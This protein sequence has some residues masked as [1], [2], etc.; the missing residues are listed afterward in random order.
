MNGFTEKT[1]RA[2]AKYTAEGCVRAYQINRRDGEGAS[3]I[4]LQYSIPNVKTTQQ[5]DAAINAGEEIVARN[6][7]DDEDEDRMWG[8]VMRDQWGR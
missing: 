2:I 1:R 5:A 7:A 8:R 6:I 4:A 3:T